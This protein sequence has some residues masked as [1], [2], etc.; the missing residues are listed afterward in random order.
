MAMKNLQ[1]NKIYILEIRDR[2]R[3]APTAEVKLDALR[4]CVA[5]SVFMFGFFVPPF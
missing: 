2:P 3:C 1:G 4:Q 5:L